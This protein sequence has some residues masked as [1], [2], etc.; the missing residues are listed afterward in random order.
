MAGPR[1]RLAPTPSGYL[2]AGNAWSFLLTW[3]CA[4]SRGGTVHLRI[5]DLDV[6]RVRPEYLEDIFASLEWMG[7]DWDGGPRDAAGFRARFSQ[8]SRLDAYREA[9]EALRNGGARVYPC[10]CSR[11]RAKDDSA[12]LGIPGIYAGTCR[13]AGL[14]WERAAFPGRAARAGESPGGDLALR[15]GVP[16]NAEVTLRAMAGP[17]PVLHPGRE[18]GDFLVWKKDGL[19][20]YQLASVV[21]DEALGIDCVVRGS[22]L[23]PSSGAQA[24]LAER[25]GARGFRA[26]A[27]LHHPL[28]LSAGG[29]KLSKSAGS[30]SLLAWRNRGGPGPLLRGFA[31]WLGMAPEAIHTAKDMIPAFSPERVPREDRAWPAFAAALEGEYS[32]EGNAADGP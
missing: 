30:E 13:E 32:D 15:A 16:G 28:L 9:L 1:T 17:P 5:D 7:L 6:E 31:A 21:D 19:P 24:W 2:H 25:I 29:E 23:L 11:Q 10:A 26:A 12:A 27:F 3:L 18:M 22:D 8:R 4:R 20:A 14:S